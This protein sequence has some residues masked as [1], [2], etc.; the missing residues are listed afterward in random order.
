MA[1]PVLRALLSQ[2]PAPGTYMPEQAHPPGEVHAPAYS[3]AGRSK[4]RKR[5]AVPAPNTYTLPALLG[6]HTVGKR[7]AAAITM[8]GRQTTGGFAQDL[9][10][11]PGPGQY[12]ADAKLHGSRAPA[13][14][15][16]GRTFLPTGAS[17]RPC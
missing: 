5:D 8:A 15:M 14:S 13:Y 7:S 1:V 12:D 11:T 6:P 17:P 16:L 9:A 4:Y 3:M 10:K 2:T